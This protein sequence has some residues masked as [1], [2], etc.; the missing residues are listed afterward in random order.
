MAKF[1][2][3]CGRPLKEGEI[4]NC[5]DKN[6]EEA[7]PG[8]EVAVDTQVNPEVEI[9]LDEA[10][11]GN[12][13]EVNGFIIKEEEK[14]SDAEIENEIESVVAEGY[15]E[16]QQEE[17]ESQRA[18]TNSSNHQRPDSNPKDT[19]WSSGYQ[20]QNQKTEEQRKKEESEFEKKAR[21]FGGEIKRVMNHLV[22]MMKSPVKE[23]RNIMNIDDRMGIYMIV[24]HIIAVTVA[25]VLA[26]ESFLNHIMYNIFGYMFGYSLLKLI[27]C[28]VVLVG[29]ADYLLAALLLFTTQVIFN[30]KTTYNKM[31]TI[32]GGMAITNSAAILAGTVI[33]VLFSGLGALIILVGIVFSSL[34]LVFAYSDVIMLETDKKIF[35]L[36]IAFTLLVI[37]MANI[38]Y[39]VF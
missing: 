33:G 20:E 18:D 36:L 2:S 8:E 10:K 6:H 35:S 17:K 16:Y 3:E 24:I 11:S 38:V 22:P 31:M 4:C 23:I 13:E 34:V 15:K 9:I 26:E 27:A 32:V 25:T 37:V 7:K 28:T 19:Q 12:T 21:K 5:T 30:Y 39:F 14:M 1:C 29:V